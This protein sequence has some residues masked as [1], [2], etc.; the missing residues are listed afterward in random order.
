MNNTPASQ[1]SGAPFPATRWS[2]VAEA[3]DPREPESAKA[4][5]T[6]C[7]HYWM[8]LYAAVRRFGHAPPDAADLTQGFFERLLEK[9]WLRAAD[10]QKGRFRTFLMVALK[11]YMANE[12]HRGR[13]AKR[14]GGLSFVPLDT[15]LS[16]RLY[17]KSGEHSLSPEELFDKRWALTLIETSLARIEQEYGV[18][19]HAKE[20]RLLK[21]CLT[22]ARGEIDYGELA[23]T[24]G[25]SEGAARVA[26]HRIRKRY[27]TLFREEIART[28]CDESEVEDEL[29]AL[30][31]ALGR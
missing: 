23:V 21:P 18:T 2:V 29:R 7:R 3:R 15:S 12:Y 25:L 8:P 1:Q 31:V 27:R 19:D 17:V 10:R 26:V 9:D 30:M 28:V 4:L 13:A 11:R 20:F 14:G 24:L 16:E 6:L 5:E 22:A